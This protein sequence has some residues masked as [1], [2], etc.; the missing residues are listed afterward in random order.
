M[1]TRS[2]DEMVKILLNPAKLDEVVK[3]PQRKLP[4]VATEAKSQTIPNT[5]VYLTIVGALAAVAIAALIGA[6]V[7]VGSGKNAPDVVI[8]LGSAAIG[9]LAGTLVPQK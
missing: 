1:G 5:P 6:I 7:L 2:A 8:A 3:D 9:A 4:E